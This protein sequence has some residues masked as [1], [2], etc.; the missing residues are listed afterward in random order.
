[1]LS[2]AHGLFN[3]QLATL[4]QAD[5]TAWMSF[6]AVCMLDVA[7]ELATH[8]PSYEDIAS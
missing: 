8:D 4:N 1:M 7:L 2:F 3:L 5:G 6:F